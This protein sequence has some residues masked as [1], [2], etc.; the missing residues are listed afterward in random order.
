MV[1][2]ESNEIPGNKLALVLDEMLDSDPESPIT[3][4]GDV[5]HGSKPLGVMPESRAFKLCWEHYIAHSAINESFCA[6]DDKQST[7][8]GR[9]VRIH[10]KSHF[11]A[12]VI[13]VTWGS[14]DCPGPLTHVE[15]LCS[16]QTINVAAVGLPTIRQLP[17]VSGEVAYEAAI[18]GGAT[19]AR[20]R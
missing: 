6:L 19:I 8:S 16:D 2:R 17:V 14:E 13:A 18:G 12:F 10:T 11:L 15:V 20:Q 5:L 1:L 9:L 3:V 7:A 4:G